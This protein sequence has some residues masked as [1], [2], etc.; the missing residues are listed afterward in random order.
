MVTLVMNRNYNTS[1]MMNACFACGAYA[2]EKEIRPTGD[3]RALAV[4]PHCAHPRPFAYLPLFIVTG[5]STTGKSSVCAQAAARD[6]ARIHF[7]TDILWGA[8][9]ASPA[10]DYAGY[11]NHWLRVAK[12]AAQGGRPVVLYSSAHPGQ[13]AACP[14][15]RYFHSIHVLALVCGPAELAERLRARPRWRDSGSAQFIAAMPAYNA[16]FRRQAQ[17]AALELLDT[18]GQLLPAVV[19]AVLAWIEARSSR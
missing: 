7:D 17:G 4:C 10:D 8:L 6:P 15:R 16:W 5:A 11:H 3:G 18:T 9:P 12:N 2:V 14:E 13:I 19:D 1:T